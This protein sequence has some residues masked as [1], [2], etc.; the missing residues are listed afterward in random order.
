[1]ST[2]SGT[3]NGGGARLTSK[4]DKDNRA[5]VFMLERVAGKSIAEIATA[6]NCSRPTVSTYLAY[7]HQQNLI[8]NEARQILGDKLVPLAIA[9][10]EMHLRQGSLEAAQDLLFGTG[11]LQRTSNVKHEAADANDTLQAF[12]EAYFKAKDTIVVTDNQKALPGVVLSDSS[13]EPIK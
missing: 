3:T 13:H 4:A 1:M 2:T 9:V 11:I 7:G 8:I 5:L 12:R 6:Y 10:Y